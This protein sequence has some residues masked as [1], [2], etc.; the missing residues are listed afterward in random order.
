MN[1]KDIIAKLQETLNK[2]L[3]GTNPYFISDT[4][5]HTGLSGYAIQAIEDTVINTIVSTTKG[6]SMNSETMLAGHIWYVNVSELTLTS[7]AVIVYNHNTI[8]G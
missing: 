6:N 1:N 5:A 7:G 8:A 3:T 4:N 2:A